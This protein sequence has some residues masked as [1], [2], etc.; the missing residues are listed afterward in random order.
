MM[1]LWRRAS[2]VCGLLMTAAHGAT[3]QSSVTGIVRDSSGRPLE[4][5]E[6]VI[7]AIGK[8][9]I[10]DQAGRYLLADVPAGTR[11]V[12]A[13]ML[14]YV[15]A[16]N[17]VRV[18][19][20][21]SRQSDFVLERLPQ[22]LDTL[23]VKDKAR[24]AGVGL[25]AFEE[26]RS[27]GFGKF[28]DS[29]YLR[30]NEQRRLGDILQEIPGTVMLTPPRQICRPRLGCYN[31]P[32]T[33]RVAGSSRVAFIKPCFMEVYLDGAMVNRGSIAGEQAD[34]EGA[35]DLN[36]VT[37]TGFAAV[38]VYRSLAETPMIFQSPTST[39]GVLMLWT[40][41]SQ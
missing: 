40:R 28:L 23:K 32:S 6:V 10:T 27:L 15:P 22:Q 13:R 14:G 36:M 31:P 37:T 2:I 34:W 25:A 39:C 35:F 30:Q 20:G 1:T 8:R 5:A 16:A 17:L 3:A 12:N 19:A 11:M 7:E 41:R 24:V 21:E 29:T 18:I 9:A 4:R 33:K 38:E 26:R